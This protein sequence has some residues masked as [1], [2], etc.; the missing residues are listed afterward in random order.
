[1]PENKAFSGFTKYFTDF[2]KVSM[3]SEKDFPIFLLNQ[4]YS[5]PNASEANQIGRN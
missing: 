3:E 1:M 5:A 2:I 4:M